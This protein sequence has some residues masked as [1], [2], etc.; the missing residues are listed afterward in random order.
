MYILGLGDQKNFKTNAFFA[1]KYG[2]LVSR[3]ER[4]MLHNS[5]WI[6]L[7]HVNF[8]RHP[9][10]GV[11]I[12]MVGVCKQYLVENT[13]SVLEDFAPKNT[14]HV[15]GFLTIKALNRFFEGMGEGASKSS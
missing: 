12:Q 14:A 13:D 15:H 10:Q 5:L 9:V 6:S 8:S 7:E 2:Y 11:A 3:V 4:E 1:S